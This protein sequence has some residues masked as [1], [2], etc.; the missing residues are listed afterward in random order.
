MKS[1]TPEDVL[2]I[3][4]RC[5]EGDQQSSIAKDY[6]ISQQTVS[7]IKHGLYWNSVT[8]LPRKRPVSALQ[9]RALDIY[10]ADLPVK[11]IAAEFGVSLKT[12][13]DI[14][15]GRRRATLTCHPNPRKETL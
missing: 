8:G 2:D 6:D 11:E 9:Q 3:Y 1:L 13:Y 7:G 4:Q 15:E 5:Q 14:R 10:A 12:V